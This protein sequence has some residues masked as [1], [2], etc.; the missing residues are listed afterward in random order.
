MAEITLTDAN[1]DEEVLKSDI[2]VLVDFWAT[3]CGPCKMIAPVVEEIAKENEG[4]IKVGKV[5]VDEEQRLAIRFGISSIPTL[6]VFKNGEQVNKAVGY[7]PKEQ[8][9]ALLK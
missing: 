7:M 4:K 8:L 6:L 2:P 9:E 1:F 5:N 3:W